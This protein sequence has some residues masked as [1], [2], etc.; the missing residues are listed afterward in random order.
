MTTNSVALRSPYVAQHRRRDERHLRRTRRAAVSCRAAA[1][2]AP[3]RGAGSRSSGRCA[4]RRSA[5]TAAVASAAATPAIGQRRATPVIAAANKTP[6]MSTALSTPR[7]VGRRCVPTRSSVLPPACS[8][9]S[10]RTSIQAHRPDQH[11]DV[12]IVRPAFVDLDD[13]DGVRAP[14]PVGELRQDPL[15]AR[16][17]FAPVPIFGHAA[18]QQEQRPPRLAQRRARTAARLAL[19]HRQGDLRRREDAANLAGD[20]RKG[21]NE[22][23]V[24]DRHA[25]PQ[26]AA[27]AA[28]RTLDRSA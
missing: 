24:R 26:A 7:V 28:R 14:Q 13:A 6:A 20:S 8:S 4:T 2:P 11:A 12:A 18:R 19:R 25:I 3:C 10:A 23:Q 22:M 27:R 5:A 21:L 15:R 1:P 9:T 16:P 17:G